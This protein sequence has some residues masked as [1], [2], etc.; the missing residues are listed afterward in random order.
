MDLGA[1]LNGTLTLSSEIGYANFGAG[2]GRMGLKTQI[3]PD[4]KGPTIPQLDT[5]SI[6]SNGITSWFDVGAS[7][8]GVAMKKD[9]LNQIM[10]A[11]WYG[12]AMSLPELESSLDLG[13]GV[14]EEVWRSIAEGDDWRPFERLTRA[15]DAH[16]ARLLG[17]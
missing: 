3:A 6:K 16:G 1:P 2:Y 17:E 5:G 14:V 13:D 4:Q 12:G 8:F 11:T 15:L 7:A 10:W 9:F